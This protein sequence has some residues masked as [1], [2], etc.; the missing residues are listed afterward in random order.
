MVNRELALEENSAATTEFTPI[1]PLGCGRS[2][3][4]PY[5]VWN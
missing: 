5:S 3:M 4:V 1:N 2:E